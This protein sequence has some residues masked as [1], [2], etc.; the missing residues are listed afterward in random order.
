LSS[1]FPTS[2]LSALSGL[3]LLVPLEVIFSSLSV[4]PPA[5]PLFLKQTDVRAAQNLLREMEEWHAPL[6]PRQIR[7]FHVLLDL[8]LE[9]LH[10]TGTSPSTTFELLLAMPRRE[11]DHPVVQFR[12]PEARFREHVRYRNH[13]RRW[14][15]SL[16]SRH[17]CRY[18]RASPQMWKDRLYWNQP[19]VARPNTGLLNLSMTAN[20]RPPQKPRYDQSRKKARH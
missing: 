6:L 9:S 2:T 14:R 4:A 10:C 20:G 16:G 1:R 5:I 15:T 7:C 11:P 13:L 17:Y 19:R 18:R 3:A 12:A 8:L